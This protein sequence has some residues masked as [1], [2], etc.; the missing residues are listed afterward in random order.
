M[1]L[2]SGIEELKHKQSLPYYE[3]GDIILDELLSGG[4]QQD[5]I[6]LVY[7]DRKIIVDILLKTIVNTFKDKDFS[8]KVVYIDG[9]NRFNPYMISKLAAARRLSPRS[10]L[11]SFLI[12]RAFT[13]EQMV[14]VLENRI[15]ELDQVKMLIVS[16]I[17]TLW[18]NYKQ[19]TFEGLLKAIAGIKKS[20][21]KNN[22]VLILTAP[23]NKYSE[24]RPKGGKYLAH[25]GSVLIMI[26]NKKR[27]IE[28][29]LIQHPSLPEKTVRK[30]KPLKLKRNLKKPL[31]NLTLDQFLK[32]KSE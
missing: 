5:L 26:N 12:S 4:F 9:N 18:P 32:S 17:T 1:D 3:S 21:L 15:N 19:S 27:F 31:K 30:A 14:E 28:Y 7:G 24:F 13:F 23:L 16:G 8:K 11:E 29:S 20:L 25:F 10:V 6:Y 2:I 22:P